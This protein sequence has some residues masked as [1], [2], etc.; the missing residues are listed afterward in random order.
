[1]ES[2]S[3]V[4]ESAKIVEDMNNQMRKISNAIIKSKEDMDELVHNSKEVETL[5][6][7]I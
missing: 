3:I 1:M 7:F 2:S 5:L 4:N 6:I